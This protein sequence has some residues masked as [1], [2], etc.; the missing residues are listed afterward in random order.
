MEELRRG[1]EERLGEERER[2]GGKRKGGLVSGRGRR[3]MDG[4]GGNVGEG[5]DGRDLEGYDARGR[6]RA[7]YRGDRRSEMSEG[8]DR[9]RTILGE[10]SG[11][12]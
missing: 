6:D 3:R 8:L 2:K 10:V 12:Y 7:S 5:R 4:Y 9:R 11:R 1:E